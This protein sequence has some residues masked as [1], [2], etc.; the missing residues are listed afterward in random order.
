MKVLKLSVLQCGFKRFVRLGAFALSVPLSVS[1]SA[2]AQTTEQNYLNDLYS[3]LQGQDTL[4]YRTATYYETSNDL[5]VWMAQ[6]FCQDL[7]NG[8]NT[9]AVYTEFMAGA[10][11][12][13]SLPTQAATERL[14]YSVGLY[15]GSVMNLGSAYYCPQYQDQVVQALRNL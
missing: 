1:T 4:A 12:A 9:E 5:N 7:A 11:Q 8:G 13:G 2:I 6:S 10:M 15:I 3:F 14:N